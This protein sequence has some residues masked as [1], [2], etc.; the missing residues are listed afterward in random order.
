[1]LAYVCFRFR[2]ADSAQHAAGSPCALCFVSPCTWLMDAKS[3]RLWSF[4]LVL[5]TCPLP[6]THESTSP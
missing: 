3:R 4:G 2:Y 5:M 1:M 6:F